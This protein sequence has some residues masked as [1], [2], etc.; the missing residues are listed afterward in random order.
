[1][2]RLL[3]PRLGITP[4][5]LLEWPPLSHP[6]GWTWDF[7]LLSQKFRVRIILIWQILSGG[8]CRNVAKPMKKLNTTQV[9]STSV[10]KCCL[11]SSWHC[12]SLQLHSQKLEECILVKIKELC[13]I[14]CLHHWFVGI[15]FSPCWWGGNFLT[16]RKVVALPV[17]HLGH[18]V[19][20][21][22]KLFLPPPC[23]C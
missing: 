17:L 22:P 13:K 8:E 12:C 4:L 20:C 3:Q 18:V 7:S 6:H 9:W 16:K 14:F 10:S 2:Q 11:P 15:F 19:H 23:P 1:M 21:T 5:P